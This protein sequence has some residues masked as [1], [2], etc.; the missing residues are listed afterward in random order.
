MAGAGY[1]DAKILARG[2]AHERSQFVFGTRLCLVPGDEGLVANPVAPV[3]ARPQPRRRRLRD[4]RHVVIPLTARQRANSRARS[5]RAPTPSYAA[6]QRQTT[7]AVSRKRRSEKDLILGIHARVL[8]C[9]A[10]VGAAYRGFSRQPGGRRDQQRR[11]HG[12]GGSA[13]DRAASAGALGYRDARQISARRARP[14]ERGLVF[15]AGTFAKLG[16]Q[17]CA[18]TPDSDRRA[19]SSPDRVDAL[20]W[21][22][23]TCSVSTAGTRGEIKPKTPRQSVIR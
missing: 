14:R 17:L 23:R 13:P 12:G 9:P 1:A 3:P 2:L 6:R 22:S 4:I 18:L 5:S 19:N 15:H 8:G 20:I 16:T 21:R 7:Q 11:R 10:R